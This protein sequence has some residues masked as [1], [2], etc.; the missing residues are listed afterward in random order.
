MPPPF[1]DA[2]SKAEVVVEVVPVKIVRTEEDAFVWDVKVQTTYKGDVQEGVTI[3]LPERVWP[4]TKDQSSQMSVG[5]PFLLFPFVS[6]LGDLSYGLCDFSSRSLKNEPLTAEEKIIL[7]DASTS[8]Q[9]EPYKCKDGTQHPRCAVDGTV[10]NYFAPVCM[11]H[12]GDAGTT[13]FSD[14]LSNHLNAEAIA[15]VKAEGIVEGYADGTYRPDTTINRAEFVKIVE[16]AI[17][18]IVIIN[19]CLEDPID[20]EPVFKDVPFGA[21]YEAYVCDAKGRRIIAGYPDGT[22]RPGINI[23]FVE[24]AKIINIAFDLPFKTSE[25]E[26]WYRP[27]V[28]KLAEENAIPTSITRFDQYITRGEMAEM[29]YRLKA[30]V[31]EKSSWTYEELAGGTQEMMSV[32]LYFGD[33]DVIAVSDCSATKSVTRSIVKTAS[34]ADSTLRLLFQGV[35][36]AEKAQGL[37]S[38]FDSFERPLAESYRGISVAH[39]VAT[40]KFTAPAMSYLN[41]AACMQQVIKASIEQT[42]LEFPSIQSVQYSVDG[43][44]VTEWDA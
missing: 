40:V 33:Q 3:R 21:W 29:I 11:T 25:S 23:S 12:G 14:V 7:H 1:S 19:A 16:E 26:E 44:I 4:S 8:V 30:G 13:S 35:T 24:A 2:V 31:K 37:V 32:T 38:I 42:L 41:S 20:N 43:K 9:C 17:E 22:F 39:G 6:N 34:V 5:E 36:Q 10:I 18:D 27:F 28:Q 15:Y